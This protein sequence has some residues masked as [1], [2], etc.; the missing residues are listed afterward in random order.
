MEKTLDKWINVDG[1]YE[2]GESIEKIN[3]LLVLRTQEF[4][5]IGLLETKVYVK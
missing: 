5:N 1:K 4:D 2:G 3:R